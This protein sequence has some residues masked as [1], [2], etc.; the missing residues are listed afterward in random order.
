MSPFALGFLFVIVIPL[1]EGVLVALLL[2]EMCNRPSLALPL[3]GRIVPIWWKQPKPAP[4]TTADVLQV[5]PAPNEVAPN[6]VA[7]SGEAPEVLVAPIPTPDTPPT[8]APVAD[9]EVKQDLP[10]D[11][12]TS[13]FDGTENIPKDFTVGNVL[14]AMTMETPAAD[15][16]GFESIIDASALSGNAISDADNASADDMN[17]DDLKSLEEALP[18]TKID[19]SQEIDHEESSEIQSIG[20]EVLGEDFD[21]K[22]LEQRSQQAGAML[23]ETMLDVR[24]DASSGIVQVSSPFIADVVPQF[25]DLAVPQTV[26]SMFSENWVQDSGG[27]TETSEEDVAKFC[28]TEESGPL[29]VRKKKKQG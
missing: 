15:L 13:V 7:E 26:L 12:G 23:A 24:E 10:L 17:A 9:S 25:A 27:V 18:G 21:F 8:A 20:K 1:A 3:N 2:R 28:F 16:H 11:L 5:E 19:L 14:D 22:S 6:K 29:V 4:E